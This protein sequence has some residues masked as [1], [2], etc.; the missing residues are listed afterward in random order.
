[1]RSISTILAA[2]VGVSSVASA[3]TFFIDFS[4]SNVTEGSIL[5]N[6]Y[7][8]SHGVSFQAGGLTGPGQTPGQNFATNTDMTITDFDLG[9]LGAAPSGR[10]LHALGAPSPAPGSIYFQQGR[11]WQNENGDPVFRINFTQPVSSFF[12]DFRGVGID[13]NQAVHSR[14][15]AFQ[16]N[17]TQVASAAAS[18][19]FSVST[20]RLSVFSTANPIT[21]IIVNPG[22]YNDWVGIDNLEWTVFQSDRE[23]AVDAD[24][25][26]LTATN[27]TGGIPAQSTHRAV[28]GPV[29]TANRTV[30]LNAPVSINQARFNNA[31]A[32]YSIVGTSTLTLAGDA[33]QIAVQAGQHSI[34]TPIQTSTALLISAASG[35]GITTGPIVGAGGAQPA[36]LQVQGAGQI[37]VGRFTFDGAVNVASGSKLKLAPAS[38]P[39]RAKSL[40]TSAPDSVDLAGNAIIIDGFTSYAAYQ[41]AARNGHYV[42]TPGIANAGVGLARVSDLGVTSFDSVPVDSTDLIIKYSL[43]GDGDLNGSVDFADLLRTAQNYNT[44]TGAEWF[45]GD[46][47]H[48][49][50][51]EFNDLLS[52]AQN[53]GL[54]LL[55]SGQVRVDPSLV[56]RFAQ[57]WQLALSIVPEPASIAL[58][59]SGGLI[60]MRRRRA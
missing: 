44:T 52:I 45:D 47:D 36:S 27:W 59:V 49:G 12:A 11:G 48:D 58:F 35:S 53:Y 60:A 7:L 22:D 25:N 56:G 19:Q 33:P 8:S 3:Q 17:G 5:G 54:S 13:N 55:L 34:A 28:F 21:S 16:A 57:D 37:V 51:I 32:S 24:G 4:E 30:T 50:D 39:S 18:A 38:G 9:A 6:Q 40:T 46:V 2:V 42:S 26:W 29:I 10:M 20:Q 14:L 23:W 15:L 1:L 31:V 43:L 41:N